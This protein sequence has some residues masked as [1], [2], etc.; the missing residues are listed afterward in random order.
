MELRIA[1]RFRVG[2]K[3]GEGNHGEIYYIEDMNTSPPEEGAVKLEEPE[4]SRAPQLH[5]EWKIYKLLGDKGFSFKSHDL[6][7]HQN[8]NNRGS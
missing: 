3:I 4:R 2:S 7:F 5:Y 6:L 1:R 8:L